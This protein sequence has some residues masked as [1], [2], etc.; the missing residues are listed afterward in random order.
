MEKQALEEKCPKMEALE[1]LLALRRDTCPKESLKDYSD[2][3]HFSGRVEEVATR[4]YIST[5]FE[6]KLG[7]LAL[8][9]L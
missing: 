9:I 4:I 5:I 2:H 3:H 1:T 7:G 6:R 8:S